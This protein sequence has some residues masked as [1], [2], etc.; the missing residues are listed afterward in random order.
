MMQVRR[1]IAAVFCGYV[2]PELA[3]L[4]TPCGNAIISFAKLEEM[5]LMRHVALTLGCSVVLVS[6]LAVAQQHNMP[7]GKMTDEQ[8]IK[9]AMSAA[10]ETI[11]KDA[12][13]IDVGSDG[14]V[15]VVRKGTNQFTCMA[16]N[17]NTPGPDPMCADRNAM[18]WVEAWLNKKEPPK[19]KVG[20]MYMLA[21]GTDAS[22]TDPYAQ[23]PEANNNW[24]ETGP[25][26]MIV[27]AKGLLDAYPRSP[28][29]DTSV[30]YVMWPDTPYE[31]LMI[32]VR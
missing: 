14:K 22:N 20:F 17:P 28:R 13:I 26:V 21:G 9:S 8:I 11:G 29:P 16:D 3:F 31:H 6:G 32:P 10:P 12:T 25:H 23:K 2:G 15:R 4:P 5:V 1:E 7:S 27:G 24:V 19:N 18:E 30:P